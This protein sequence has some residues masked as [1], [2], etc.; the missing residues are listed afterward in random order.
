VK[1][2]IVF[3]LL[4]SVFRSFA[5]ENPGAGHPDN[6]S[7]QQ[8]YHK[9]YRKWMVGAGSVAGYGTSMILFSKSWYKDYPRS[10]F[11]TFNDG[12]EWMQM[13]KVGHAWAAYNTSRLTSDMWQWTGLKPTTS[14]VLGTGSS[15]LYLLSVEYLDG[16]SAE[17]GW[18]WPDVLADFSGAGLFA[19]QEMVWKQQKIQLKFSSH[20]KKY[21]DPQLQQRANQLF[22]K[23][24]SERLLKDYNAQTYWLSF[25]LKKLIPASSLPQWLNVSVGYGASGMFGGYENVARDKNGNITFDRRDIK[26]FRQW[27]LSPD[28]DLTRIRTKSH[29]LK[30]VF[31]VFNVL[32]LPSP[33]IEYSNGRMKVKPLVF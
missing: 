31:S 25:N 29:F 32:K 22:G 23:S 10:S 30:T 16:R 7:G 9:K 17:W 27:F 18:S 13:D 21:P 24:F 15:L 28:I 3:I 19:V 4:F 11:H 33:A 8:F 6:D 26:R 1:T 2:C 5:Q 14:V 20:Y 12:G